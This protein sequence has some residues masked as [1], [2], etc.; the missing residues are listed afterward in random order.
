MKILCEEFGRNKIHMVNKNK[1]KIRE[2]GESEIKELGKKIKENTK[3][4]KADR[5][6]VGGK[7]FAPMFLCTI[8][9]CIYI[10][11]LNGYQNIPLPNYL[12]DLKVFSIIAVGITI[13]IFEYAYKYDSGKITII[14]I[15]SLV[16]S[17]VILSLHYVLEYN[18]YP[19]QKYLIFFATIFVTYYVLKTIIICIRERYKC[20]KTANDIREI[21]KKEEI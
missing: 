13:C 18:I 20:R 2:L 6:K 8:V 10:L 9:M 21:V 14:G 4:T 17:F 15:E 5:A 7:L 1:K 19:Y 12:I 11:V 3:I 16:A